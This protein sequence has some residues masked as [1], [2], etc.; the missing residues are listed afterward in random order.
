[1]GDG[2]EAARLHSAGILYASEASLSNV[3]NVNGRRQQREMDHP[4]KNEKGGNVGKS[5]AHATIFFSN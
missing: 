3:D 1:M 4:M 5:W 2:S